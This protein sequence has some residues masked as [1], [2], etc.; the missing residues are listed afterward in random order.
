M[1]LGPQELGQGL[2]Q[3]I[4]RGTKPG[5]RESQSRQGSAPETRSH[6]SRAAKRWADLRDAEL[7]E[8]HPWR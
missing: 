2:H 8:L 5:T 4:Q 3:A 7:A 1:K 6:G